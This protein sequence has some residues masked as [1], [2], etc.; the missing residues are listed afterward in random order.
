V[1]GR[2]ADLLSPET[3]TATLPALPFNPTDFGDVAG[4]AFD[5]ASYRQ[6]VPLSRAW[7]SDADSFRER[8]DLIRERL[9]RDVVDEV[10]KEKPDYGAEALIEEYQAR[11]D[12]LIAEGRLAEPEKWQGIRTRAEIEEAT[13]QKARDARSKF[14]QTA[15]KADPFD[16]IAGSLAGGIAGAFTDPINLATLPFGAAAGTSILRAA[17]IEGGLNMAIEAAEAPFV[18][19]W[20]KE[21]G[22][23]YGLADTAADIAFAGVGGAAFTTALRGAIP[24]L[25][26]AGDLT[27]SVSMRALDR[28]ANSE[29]L[30]SSVREAA[31]YM[32]R[33]AHMD[34]EIPPFREEGE[35]REQLATHREAVQETQEAIR[36]QREPDFR[37]LVGPG[38]YHGTNAVFDE[39]RSVAPEE[40][41]YSNLYYDRVPTFIT[42]N[43]EVASDYATS[44]RGGGA[45]QP[46][47]RPVRLRDGL[48]IFDPSNPGHMER[49]RVAG[50]PEAVANAVS[51]GEWVAVETRAAQKSIQDAGF[52]GFRAKENG[53][54]IGVFSPTNIEP[55]FGRSSAD[56]DLV[57]RP[58]H[59]AETMQRTV[60]E[61]DTA[62][63]SDI[64][65]ADFARLVKDM[66]DMRILMDGREV[67]VH[68]LADSLGEDDAVL[69][70]IRTCAI[71]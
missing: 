29:R 21:L 7:F 18:A 13:R 39:F 35:L 55:A 1:P 38:W 67:S 69:T 59:T 53:N 71:G 28:I 66:P 20:Q 63:L 41:G 4:A 22:H 33:V 10:K 49:A 34:E 54:T 16:R 62:G 46:N 57:T 64:A 2:V 56:T 70:A 23:K 26:A 12:R 51:R 40:A 43:P 37:P 15:A 31:G 45:G 14:E 52:D 8:N 3:Q 44:N 17:L 42:D 11:T 36:N 24:A 48:D 25:R 50:L 5:D 32:S 58:A 68:E 19:A 27:G 61:A 65:Q 30:P 6:D 60:E 9:G 47:I